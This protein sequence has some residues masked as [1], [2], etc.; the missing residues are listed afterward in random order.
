M[1]RRATAQMA[2]VLDIVR[3]AHDHPTADQVLQRVRKRLPSVSLGTVY[4]NL[5]KL[6]EQG[7]VRQVELANDA[8]RFDGMV[9]DHDHFV[10]DDC[11]R[12]T[13]LRRDAVPARASM[14][15]NGFA[16]RSCVLTYYGTCPDCAGTTRRRHRQG[17]SRSRDLSDRFAA[18][19]SP[20]GA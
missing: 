2:A 8:A 1:P 3:A 7:D 13:D 16:V 15:R 20:A 5:Q 17:S 14:R 4:R 10:C 11:H 19:R 12:V 6:V 18:K 9:A